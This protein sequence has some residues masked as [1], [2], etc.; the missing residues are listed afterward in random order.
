[1]KDLLAGLLPGAY[2]ALLGIGLAVA[3]ARWYD[4]VPRRALAV[5]ALALGVLFGPA[6]FAGRVLLSA[7][8]PLAAAP[9]RNTLEPRGN[10]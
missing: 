3:L 1:M 6:L 4:A 8:L 10:P 7:D 5:F 2:L 9:Y